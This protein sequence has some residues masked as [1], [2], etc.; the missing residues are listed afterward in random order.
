MPMLNS[1]AIRAADDDPW[2]Q[3]LTLEFASG[4]TCSFYGGP[5]SVFH[6]LVNATSPGTDY[7]RHIRKRYR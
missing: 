5:A 4:G 3:I 7:H 6:E 1:S 2:T